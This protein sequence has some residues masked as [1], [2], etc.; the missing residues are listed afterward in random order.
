M[1]EFSHFP[2]TKR[3][4]PRNP[5]AIQLYSLTTPNGVKAS[6]ALEEMG[7]PYDAHLVNFATNDQMS[8]AFLSLNP[9]NK[10]P[11][12][13]DPDGPGGTPLALFESGAI[14]IY[15]AEKTGQLMTDRFATLQWLMWQMGGLG[16]MLA[17]EL[18]KGGD[19]KQPDAER[20]KRLCAEA[21]ARGLVLLSC[22]IHGNVIRLLV[23]LTASDAVLDE[24]LAHL[25]AALAATA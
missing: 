13:I 25:G 19:V 14:L 12:I 3:W 10:I 1:T 9:N 24:G 23:P 6:I 20:T 17:I 22:G 18:F 21:L 11:A 5:D 4:P 15:L 2:I 16:P 7:L 8:D